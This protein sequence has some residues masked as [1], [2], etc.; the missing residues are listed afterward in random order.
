MI[1]LPLSS[2]QAALWAL[3]AFILYHLWTKKETYV[4]PPMG[5]QQPATACDIIAAAVRMYLDASR[6]EDF[7]RAQVEQAWQDLG[8]LQRCGR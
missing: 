2:Q 8:L 4:E 1:S 5:F 6:P 3:A 7:T